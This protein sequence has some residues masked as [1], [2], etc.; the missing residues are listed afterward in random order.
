LESFLLI[1]Q[2]V[3]AFGCCYCRLQELLCFLV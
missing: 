1:C 3:F 2:G